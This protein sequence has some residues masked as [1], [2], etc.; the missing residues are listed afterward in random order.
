MTRM[1]VGELERR[2][3]ALLLE[4]VETEQILGEALGYPRYS[5]DPK[6]FPDT[7]EA[8]G[9]CVGEMTV[10]L[11]AQQLADAYKE[12]KNGQSTPRQVQ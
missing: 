1:L 3:N 10:A 4:T 11:L 6:N 9:V 7:T 8:D 12:L 5:D 2:Y